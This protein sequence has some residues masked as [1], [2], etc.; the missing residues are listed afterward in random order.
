MKVSTRPD[1]K[2]CVSD[3]TAFVE[4]VRTAVVA[5]YRMPM[6]LASGIGG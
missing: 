3:R 1:M 5:R 4:Q 6:R 2:M